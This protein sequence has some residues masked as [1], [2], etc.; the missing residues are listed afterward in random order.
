M[1]IHLHEHTHKCMACR[2][3][4][5]LFHSGLE[6]RIGV[7]RGHVHTYTDKFVNAYM[8]VYI[9]VYIYNVCVYAYIGKWVVLDTNV[10]IH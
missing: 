1:Y 2:K 3:S 10:S 7:L 9:Y 8:Y 5:F 6:R 4:K